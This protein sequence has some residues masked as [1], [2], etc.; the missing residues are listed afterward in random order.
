MRN[1]KHL[2]S[3][4]KAVGPN[5]QITLNILIS[6]RAYFPKKGW[7]PFN[8]ELTDNDIDQI[9]NLLGGRKSTPENIDSALRYRFKSINNIGILRNLIVELKED[10][11]IRWTYCAGQD[12]PSEIAYVRNFLK[13]Q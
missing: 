2:K 10:K 5:S 1:Y 9:K 13:A 7:E 3:L 8:Y 11:S 6:G 12:Y 4:I